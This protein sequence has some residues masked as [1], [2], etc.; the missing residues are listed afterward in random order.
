MDL[1]YA[2]IPTPNGSMF[3]LNMELER[4]YHVEDPRNPKNQIVYQEVEMGFYEIESTPIKMKLNS[5]PPNIC[6]VWDPMNSFDG[7]FLE[8]DLDKVYNDLT[9]SELKPELDF[10]IENLSSAQ[11]SSEESVRCQKK[12][13]GILRPH[14][15]YF[16]EIEKTKDRMCDENLMESSKDDKVDNDNVKYIIP[17]KRYAKPFKEKL[18]SKTFHLAPMQNHQKCF[19]EDYPKWPK[20]RNRDSHENN[21]K[22]DKVYQSSSNSSQPVGQHKVRHAS[23]RNPP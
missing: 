22:Q 11:Q 4:K 19:K 10:S 13:D 7:I 9:P 1:T 8:E 23:K 2:T 18:S 5:R 17:M 6:N 20:V 21:K 15:P 16:S 3:R 14:P 12:S